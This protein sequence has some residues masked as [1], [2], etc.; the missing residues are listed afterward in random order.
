M[1]ADGIRINHAALDQAASDMGSASKA[2][3]SRLEALE[4]ELNPLRNDWSGQAQASYTQA[5][6]KWDQQMRELN[7][8]LA[9]AGQTVATSN[10]DYAQADKRGAA[11]FEIG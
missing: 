1:S 10:V 4:Q 2:I 9:Q 6:A 11:S 3:D 7:T 8:I 5:K